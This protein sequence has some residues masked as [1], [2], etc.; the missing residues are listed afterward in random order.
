MNKFK[1]IFP[2][3]FMLAVACEKVID[4]DLNEAAPAIVI[5]GNLSN[6]INEIQVKVSMTSSYFDTLPSEKISGAVVKVTSDVGDSFILHESE[7]GI[8]K[9][10][11]SWFKEGGTYNLSVEA[12][13]E[14]YVASS[15]LNSPV[16]IDS[17]RFY[18]EDSPFFEQGYYVN[19][20]LDDPPGV[21]NY[22]RLKYLKNGVFQN[23]IEDLIL[24]DDRYVDG[25]TIEVSLFNQPFELNDTVALQ[26]VSLDKGAYD[27]LRT[28]RELVNNN[29][30]SAAPAN[31]NSNISNGAL[32]YFSAWSS[33]LKSVIIKW[34]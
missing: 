11:K 23:R 31:P 28:F 20:F 34:E 22:Y 24:F 13:G 5:E 9:T 12:N 15:K 26:L 30:G 2:L 18:Y 19:V 4:V 32:G 10:R 25:N 16:F 21:S 33:S 29:P 8:Y 17:V 7:N 6:S 3:I 1:Y 14:K 27:Y